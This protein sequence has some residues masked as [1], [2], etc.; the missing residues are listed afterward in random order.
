MQTKLHMDVKTFI[1]ISIFL[2]KTRLPLRLQGVTE[3]VVAV[4][5]LHVVRETGDVVLLI[6][7]APGP[8][9]RRGPG[10]LAELEGEMEHKAA[11][12]V[13]VLVR[14]VAHCRENDK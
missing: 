11:V 1:C 3:T 14:P 4:L 12:F 9:G 7:E 2:S 5:I 10:Q 6:R 13:A 8:R